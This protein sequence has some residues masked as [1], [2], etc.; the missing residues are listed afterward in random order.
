MNQSIL[1]K[2]MSKIIKLKKLVSESLKE[3][4]NFERKC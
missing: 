2:E 4:M 1:L 3:F